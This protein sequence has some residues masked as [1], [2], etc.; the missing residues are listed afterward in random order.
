MQIKIFRYEQ[1]QKDRRIQ[2][3]M[4]KYIKTIRNMKVRIKIFGEGDSNKN[5]K[6]IKKYFILR[7]K[8]KLSI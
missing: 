8:N 2:K 5:G 6:E 3:E 7:D 4:K 1:K